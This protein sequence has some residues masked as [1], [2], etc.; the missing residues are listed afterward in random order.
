MKRVNMSQLISETAEELN[1]PHENA[2]YV[3]MYKKY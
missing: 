2:K 3:N 1:I